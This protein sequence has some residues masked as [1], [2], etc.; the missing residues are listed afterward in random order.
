MLRN[1]TFILP[2]EVLP[3]INPVEV[4]DQLAA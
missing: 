1:H 2:E 3:P 4:D